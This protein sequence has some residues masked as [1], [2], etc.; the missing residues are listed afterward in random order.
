[1]SKIYKLVVTVPLGH[2]D[3]VRTAIG[4]AG[5][6]R[7]GNYSFASFSTRGIGRFKPESGANPAIGEIG[8]FEEVEEERIEC[9]MEEVVV[10]DVLVAL[11]HVHPYEE[12]VY[13]LYPIEI[14]E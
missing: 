11:R 13:D 3:A 12:I 1:M 2:A 14:R 9:Q 8:K 4:E 10:D 7:L 6:G 5:A